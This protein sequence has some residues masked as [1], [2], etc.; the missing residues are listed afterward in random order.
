MKTPEQKTIERLQ[1]RLN[2]V[3]NWLAIIA[4]ICYGFF[5]VF[6]VLSAWC[7]ESTGLEKEV[8]T[9]WLTILSSSTVISFLFAYI[10]ERIAKQ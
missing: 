5:F 9:M 7:Y 4:S 8:K 6:F 2:V 10:F 3:E 1:A